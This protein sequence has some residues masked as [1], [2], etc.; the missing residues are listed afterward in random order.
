MR[1]PLSIGS[2]VFIH[3]FLY[4]QQGTWYLVVLVFSAA[5]LLLVFTAG[6]GDYGIY[7]VGPLLRALSRAY[8]DDACPPTPR[9]A[10]LC[11]VPAKHKLTVEVDKITMRVFM[12]RGTT[13]R[14][15]QE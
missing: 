10:P 2:R 14:D 9:N 13:V 6:T 8:P 3:R 12:K 11:R 1:S 7:E 5:V 4:V 15:L